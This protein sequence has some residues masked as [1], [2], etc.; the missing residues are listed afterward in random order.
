[1]YGG[2]ETTLLTLARQR[3]QEPE[4]ERHFALCFEGRLSAELRATGV[5]LHHLGSLRIRR[6]LKVW[7]ARRALRRLLC[8]HPFDVA[9]CH[10]AWSQVIFGPVVRA[11]G[12]PLVFWLHNEARGRH[13][14]ERWARRTRP[15]LVLCNSYFTAATLQHLYPQIE[16]EVIYAPIADQFQRLGPAERCAVRAELQTPPEAA[17]IIQVGRLEDLKGHALHFEALSLLRDLPG[18]ICWQVGGAQQPAEW[19]YLERLQTL[20]ARLGIAE[21][22]R[23]TGQRRDVP[24]LLQ[25]ADLYCQPNIRPEGFGRTFVEALL[26]RLPVVTTAL[27]GACE[28]VDETCGR[29]VPP[30]DAAALAYR[31]R[32]LLNDQALRARL[33]TAG[34]ARAQ[35]LCDPITRLQQLNQ[36][37]VRVAGQ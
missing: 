33:G 13:W 1:M 5:P 18:W 16:R 22:L 8:S 14:L 10:M 11:A 32:Q 4:T 15:D 9:I 31:L 36:I 29:L 12:V 17:V 37:L 35:Q 19:R 24:R 23:F 3:L 30:N 27:G 26:N 7:R 21:R 28:I 25:A 20:A 6:P 2:V 34:Q